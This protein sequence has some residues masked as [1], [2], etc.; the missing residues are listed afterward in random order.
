MNKKNFETS[1]LWYA[2]AFVTGVGVGVWI[3]FIIMLFIIRQ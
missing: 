2:L 1:K 3:A